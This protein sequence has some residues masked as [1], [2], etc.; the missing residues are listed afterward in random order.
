MVFGIK[1]TIT[2]ALLS[3]VTSSVSPKGL[4]TFESFIQKYGRTYKQG[5]TEYLER[6]VAYEKRREDAERQNSNSEKLWTAG[7]NNLWDWTDEEYQ[8]LLGWD[9]SVR[10]ERNGHAMVRPHHQIFLQKS[11]ILDD[12]LPKEKLWSKLQMSTQVKNQGPCGSC[13]AIAAATVLEGHYEIYS[14]QFRT[15]S[16]QQMVSCTPNPRQC[17]GKGG[18]SGA[19]AELAMEWVLKNGCATETDVPYAAADESC[20]VPNA[21]SANQTNLATSSFGMIGWETLPI[22]KYEPLVRALAMDGPVVVAAAASD[23]SNYDSGIFNGCPKDTVVNHAVTAIGYG[24]EKGTKYWLIQNS[25]GDDW[26]EDGHIRLF[27]H[28]KEPY[29]GM[30]NDPQ[31]GVACKGETDPVP[32]CGMCGVLFDS[33]VPHFKASIADL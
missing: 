25:W 32:V 24:E 9:G 11:N 16:A 19:T 12:E 5:S 6:K 17:G 13:W 33:V 14:G 20:T 27:R 30:N 31:A 7:V 21:T 4:P 1:V 10:P 26:G 28:D 15:F 8:S 3:A 18:C 23:W 29:C 22:N 2:F